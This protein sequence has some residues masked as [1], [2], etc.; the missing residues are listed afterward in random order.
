MPEKGEERKNRSLVFLTQKKAIL[1]KGSVRK[2]PDGTPT[3][4]IGEKRGPEKK[5]SGF[6]KGVKNRKEKEGRERARGRRVEKT[7][8][9][10]RG[11]DQLNEVQ[12]I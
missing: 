6:G 7:S 8:P 3:T 11:R 12:I 2:T 9:E 10:Q 1:E 4:V 5:A